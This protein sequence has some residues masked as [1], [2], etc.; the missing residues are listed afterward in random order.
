M[1]GQAGPRVAFW[2]ANRLVGLSQASSLSE[3]E[4]PLHAQTGARTCDEG[5]SFLHILATSIDGAGAMSDSVSL[6]LRAPLHQ[7]VILPWVGAHVLTEE[8]VESRR[9]TRQTRI[10]CGSPPNRGRT[11]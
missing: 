8:D 5:F 2:G 4:K 9:E 6:M 1:S 3:I 10:V 7:P 11:S